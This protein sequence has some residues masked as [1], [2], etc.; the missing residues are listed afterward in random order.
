MTGRN[1]SLTA[2]FETFVDQQ[3]ESGMHQ[4]AS[5]VVKEALRRYQGQLAA[6]QAQLDDIRAAIAEGRAAIAQ[7]DVTLVHDEASSAA[8]LARFRGGRAKT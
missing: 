8:L 4:N 7:G 5:E 6:E 2:H 1:L 3:V